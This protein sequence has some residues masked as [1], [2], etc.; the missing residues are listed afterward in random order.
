MGLHSSALLLVDLQ[1]GFLHRMVLMRA[2][3]GQANA[4][5]VAYRAGWR[6]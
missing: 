6:G 4:E 1:N 3:S 2:P 5:I